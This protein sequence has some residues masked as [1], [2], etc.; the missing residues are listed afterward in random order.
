MRLFA[1][2]RS[3]FAHWCLK[4]I[5]DAIRRVWTAAHK[6]PWRQYDV[7]IYSDHG[8]CKAKS[9]W[10][11]TGYEIEEAINRALEVRGILDYTLPG[12]NDQL[13]A[14]RQYREDMKRATRV[15]ASTVVR[16]NSA[17]NMMAK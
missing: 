10:K 14:A 9:L 16:M 3:R 12:L 11:V 17:S 7:W 2:P 4:G 13:A 8:Q 6:A 1:R 5:D 15:P